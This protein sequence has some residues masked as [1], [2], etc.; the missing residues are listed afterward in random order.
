MCL[1]L[2]LKP[3]RWA[4]IV[5]LGV[6]SATAGFGGS[7]GT[8]TGSITYQGQKLK[9]GT[10]TFVNAQKD[11][12]PCEINENG[13]YSI[14]NLAPGEYVVCVETESLKPP[15]PMVLRG[16]PPAGAEKPANSPDWEDRAKRYV[17]IPATYSDPEQSTL[18][19]TVKGGKQQYDVPLK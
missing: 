1:S 5:I 8:A 14:N 6:L 9:G 3:A 2:P 17:A 16:K 7:K 19:C 11:A 12:F 15:N 4:G 18:R 13:D 10:V